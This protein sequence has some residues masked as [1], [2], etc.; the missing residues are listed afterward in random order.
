[1][2]IIVSDTTALI[3]LARGDLLFLLNNLFKTIYVPKAVY[4]ELIVKDDLV[5]L[6]VNRFKKIEVKEITDINIFEK[7]KKSKLDLG[8]SEA[9][10]LA[11]ELDL[12]LIID[13][14]KGRKVAQSYGLNIVGVLGLILENYRQKFITYDDVIYYFEVAQK[15]GLR[16][17]KELKKFFIEKLEQIK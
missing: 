12:M 9:I 8:E 10:T 16:L 2:N 1:M 4:E 14:R 7:V 11:L 5:S 6:R 3:N 17:N 15:N 13:E